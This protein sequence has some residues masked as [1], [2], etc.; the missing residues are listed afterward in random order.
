[1]YRHANYR[2]VFWPG[3]LS[4]QVAFYLLLDWSEPSVNLS[5]LDQPFNDFVYKSIRAGHVDAGLKGFILTDWIDHVRSLELWQEA[6]NLRD[7]NSWWSLKQSA[8]NSIIDDIQQ[9]AFNASNRC[10]TLNELSK[11]IDLCECR[12]VVSYDLQLSTKTDITGSMRRPWNHMIFTIIQGASWT[13][14][15]HHRTPLPWPSWQPPHDRPPW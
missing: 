1:M 7:S 6:P 5:C 14:W 4:T 10:M 9:R 11:S 13:T 12:E 2:T 15:W 3:S 8:W